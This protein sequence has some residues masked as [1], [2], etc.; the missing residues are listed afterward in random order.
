MPASV[1]YACILVVTRKVVRG[2]APGCR[3]IGDDDTGIGVTRENFAR[4][5]V[6]KGIAFEN[7]VGRD[8]NFRGRQRKL[9]ND[10][11]QAVPP[12]CRGRAVLPDKAA[13]L[14]DR[15]RSDQVV[16]IHASATGHGAC[17]CADTCEKLHD[18]ACFS[19]SCGTGNIKRSA[20]VVPFPPKSKGF[21]KIR[22]K[23][24]SRVDGN[25]SPDSGG[26]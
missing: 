19:A 25:D 3:V 10:E 4:A 8:P 1:D 13:L 15:V 2:I 18:T 22:V 12:S 24:V 6:D 17:A 26:V 20:R 7:V 11:H 14:T 16:F 5:V 21:E 9:V 23:T